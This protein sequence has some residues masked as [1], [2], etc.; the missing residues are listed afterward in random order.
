M[1]ESR[2]TEFPYPQRAYVRTGSSLER[3]WERLHRGDR[4]LLLTNGVLER[5]VEGGGTF[6]IE[7]VARAV[8][9][10]AAP[11]APSTALA[12]Q[13]AVTECWTEPLED[14]ATL[15]VLAVD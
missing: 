6:G 9:G 10:A 3:N 13:Q 7:G 4:L 5:S 14:D 8:E 15:L 11:T 1:P 12:I 2:W